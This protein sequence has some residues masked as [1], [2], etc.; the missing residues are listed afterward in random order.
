MTTKFLDDKIWN[1]KILLSWRFPR[2]TAFLGDF[3]LLPTPK[4]KANSIFIV[5]SPPLNFGPASKEKQHFLPFWGN[6]E[7]VRGTKNAKI[8]P[9]FG[10]LFWGGG[11]ILTIKLGKIRL[12]A[13]MLA[14]NQSNVEDS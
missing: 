9:K 3:P 10:T 5:V 6:E 2:K 13:K 1:F 7:D 12:L 8:A 14:T 4:K 11:A